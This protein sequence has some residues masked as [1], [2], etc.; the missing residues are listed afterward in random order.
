MATLEYW[1]QL[2]NRPWDAC[3]HNIDRM[4]GQNIMT[5]DAGPAP[6]SVF[7]SSAVGGPGHTVTMYKPLSKGGQRIDALIYR[8]YKPPTDLVN[9]SDAWTVPD[10]RKVN[11][12]DI[13]EPNPGENGTMGTIPGPVIEGKVGDRIIVHF[14]N[15]DHRPMATEHCCHSIHP[16]GVV[17]RPQSDGAYP[18]SP[19]AA[20]P[21][22]PNQPVAGS[23]GPDETAL[24]AAVPGF[25]GPFKKGDRVPPD[26]TFT[27]T[28][29]TFGWP[30][31]AGVWLYHD[32]SI[33]DM[34][35]VERGAIGIIVIHN[36]ADADDVDIRDPADPTKFDIAQLPGGSP[37]GSPIFTQF[38]PFDVATERVALL[39]HQLESLVPHSAV[40]HVHGAAAATPAPPAHASGGHATAPAAA[41]SP[42]TGPAAQSFIFQQDDFLFQVSPTLDFLAS[43]GLRRY[44]TPP[45]KLLMLQLLHRLEGAPMCINGRQYL[46]N[47]PTIVS[48][49]STLMRC[50]VVGMGSEFHTFHLHGHRWVM[51]GAD[52]TTP[53]A[54]QNSVQKTA[55]SQF[56]DTRTFGPAN[57]FVFTMNGAS[58]SFM[59]AGGPGADDS[60]G[61]WHMHCHVLMHMMMG[62]MGSLLIVKGGEI[63]TTLPRGVPCPGDAVVVGTK[64]VMVNDF[65]FAPPTV[66]INS[67]DT[68]QW[69]WMAN[70]HSVTADDSSFD[71]GVHN[72]GFTFSRMFMQPSGTNIPYYCSIHGAPGGVGMS[73]VVHIN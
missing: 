9:L 19:P 5:R 69:M 24:W 63:A 15:R 37:T 58:G 55:V 71:S 33:C 48:G 38:F 73:G 10:D 30:S 70:N 52:G 12:W 47:T 20:L 34:D 60:V 18:L 4:T 56:E 59:R 72:S 31:T 39:P 61:E 67:G 6:V 11:P 35:N 32:H 29:E 13:N 22:V 17:F 65:A 25:T 1:L 40:P 54:I 64:T 43:F 45:T 16:H 27:Y 2:E 14:R 42:P 49:R 68:V 62:M 26:G 36:P 21:A 3:P 46:G 53:A 23:P 8:R 50:G 66:N 57:S 51:P 44:R 41:S 7:L 28:W